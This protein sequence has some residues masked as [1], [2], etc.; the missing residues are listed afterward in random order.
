MN[1]TEIYCIDNGRTATAD[2]LN[3][4]DKRL[5]VAIEGSNSPITLFK[6]TPV[7]KV[8]SGRFAGL[9]FTSTGDSPKK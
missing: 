8:Y 3:K 1:K 2:I 4:S 5:Q 9:E 6:K 7:D